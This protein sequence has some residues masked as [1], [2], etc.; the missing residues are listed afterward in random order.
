MFEIAGTYATAVCY[1]TQIEETAIEQIRTM[2]DQEFARVRTSPLCRTR[3]QE[4]AA[5]SARP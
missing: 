4:L 2:C 1:A 5:P 3:I